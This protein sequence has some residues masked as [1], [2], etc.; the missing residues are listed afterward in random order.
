MSF[1]LVL[2]SVTLNDLEGRNGVNF[3]LFQL[4]QVAPGAHCVKAISSPDE[5]LF[6]YYCFQLLGNDSDTC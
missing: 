4:I 3:T 5:F 2:K 1:R 6:F